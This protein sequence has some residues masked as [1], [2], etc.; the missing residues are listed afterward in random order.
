MK[1]RDE[2]LNLLPN[3]LSGKL[4]AELRNDKKPLFVEFETH[5]FS[6]H[7]KSD[8]REYVPQD[9]DEFWRKND[10]LEK[11]GNELNFNVKEDIDQRI[12]KEIERSVQEAKNDLFPQVAYKEK[13][14]GKL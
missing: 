7:S 4:I 13:N 14:N 9:L 2:I 3:E 6:G 8:K 10:P 1:N 12:N 5:R 11:I